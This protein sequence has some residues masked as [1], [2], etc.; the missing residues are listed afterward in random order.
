M[1]TNGEVLDLLKEKIG[2]ALKVKRISRSDKA[3]LEIMQLFVIYMVDDHPK[4]QAM[5][6]VFRPAMWVGSAAIISLIG[7]VVSGRVSIVINP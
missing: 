5:W 4:T 7:V 1:P 2:A 3:M 6:Q